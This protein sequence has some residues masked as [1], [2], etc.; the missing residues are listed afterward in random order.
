VYRPTNTLGIN[1]E[2][3][4]VIQFITRYT[5]VHAVDVI[6]IPAV[7]V[8]E[9][10]D[11]PHSKHYVG[12]DVIV[13]SGFGG[14]C[15]WQLLG[16]P[17]IF[18]RCWRILG[19]GANIETMAGCSVNSQLWSV[20]SPCVY[21]ISTYQVS[22]ATLNFMPIIRVFHFTTCYLQ[23]TCVCVCVCARARVCVVGGCVRVFGILTKLWD[24]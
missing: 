4:Y 3:T 16:I 15:I 24:R 8:Y 11:H 6:C 19:A 14:S 12:N 13:I 18:T 2:E 7:G 9:D 17:A 23:F 20:C 5:S 10:G 1:A 22:V 21:Y